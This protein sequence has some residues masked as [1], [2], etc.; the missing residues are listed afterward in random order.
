MLFICQRRF[1]VDNQLALKQGDYIGSYWGRR[2]V[3]MG[4]SRRFYVK[5]R[6]RKANNDRIETSVLLLRLW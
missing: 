3:Q 4:H 6:K 1:M 5:L 2:E